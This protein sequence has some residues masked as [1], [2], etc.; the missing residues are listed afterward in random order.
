[1]FSVHGL[2]NA[3]TA[4]VS[5]D[6]PVMT[7][8]VHTAWIVCTQCTKWRYPS[9]RP[10]VYL[11]ETCYGGS[12][13]EV[14]QPLILKFGGKLVFGNRSGLAETMNRGSVP[15]LKNRS[16]GATYWSVMEHRFGGAHFVQEISL[17]YSFTTTRNVDT[18]HV[19]LFLQQASAH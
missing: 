6:I 11:S 5:P 14:L 2:W 12:A 9:V 19:R 8:V 15:Y 4:P 7:C 18:P 3:R 13:V 17:L 1:M 16:T 10:S